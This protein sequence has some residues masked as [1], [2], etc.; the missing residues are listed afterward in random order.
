MRLRFYD[1]PSDAG[2]P[3]R[4]ELHGAR[5]RAMNLRNSAPPVRTTDA[6]SKVTTLAQLNAYHENYWRQR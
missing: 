5:L 2:L 6:S 1:R 3:D 4:P